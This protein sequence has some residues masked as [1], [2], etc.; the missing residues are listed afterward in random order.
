MTAVTAGLLAQLVLALLTVIIALTIPSRMRS[1]AS[2]I[3][4]ALISAVGIITAILTLAGQRGGIGLPLALPVDPLTLSPTR[5]G[6]LFM[7]IVSVV[8]VLVSIYGIGYAHGASASRTAWAGLAVFLTGMQLVPAAA[9]SVS[10]LLMWE[11][12]A[13]GSTILMAAGHAQRSQVASAAIWYSVMSQ[14]SFLLLL[15]GFAVLASA[16]GSTSFSALRALA[17]GSPAAAVG[18]LLLI[19]GFGSKAGLVPLHVWLPRAHPEAPSH[20]S[21]AMSAAMVKMGVYGVLLVCVGLF[22]GAP[23]WWGLLI[24]AFGG[25]SAIYGILQASVSSGLKVLLAYSTTENLGLIFLAVGASVLLRAYHA[26][27]AAEAALIAAGLLTVSHALFKT[28]LFLGAGAIQHATGETDLDRLGGLLKRMPQTAAAFV[29]AALAA[30]AL[31]LSAGFVAEWTLLQALVHGSRAAGPAAVVLSVAMPLGVAVVALTAGLS[32]LTF[33]KAYGIAFLARSRSSAAEAAAE[34]PVV[35]R[36]SLIAGAAAILVTG[37]MPGPVGEALAAAIT[38]RASGVYS[39]GLGGISFPAIEVLLDPAA[40]L[41]VAA[42]VAV[43]VLV[44]VRIMARRHPV[45]VSPLSWAGGGSRARPRMQY[46]ATSYAEPLVRVFDDVLRPARDVQVTHL[47]ESRYLVERVQVQ[48]RLADG[49]ETGLY[50]PFLNLVQR[51]GVVARNAQNGS[52]R[53][54]LSYSLTALLVVLVVVAL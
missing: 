1:L 2:G 19:A 27:A 31:P 14:L 25:V 24:M 5:L 7:L 49:I 51:F 43:P 52:I 4:C 50:R 11:A 12:M 34:V 10:F 23:A 47:G 54:Y 3:L 46:T 48:Q 36:V 15:G 33:V 39:A 44:L 17:P 41:L 30:A 29:L 8:G 32:L 22:P 26:T 6:G 45:R 16:A 21:A 42:V 53:R 28:V 20:I 9:D 35:M 13:L 38:G 40:L 37:L 18:F